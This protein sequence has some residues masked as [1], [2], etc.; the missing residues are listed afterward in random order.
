MYPHQLVWGGLDL[1][2]SYIVI[3]VTIISI[4][5]SR[6]KLK[7]EWNSVSRLFLVLYIWFS[8]TTVFAVYRDVALDLWI[9]FSKLALLFL[10][11]TWVTNDRSKLNA[12]I[13]CVIIGTSVFAIREGG[14]SILSAGKH[15]ISGP[16]GSS[17]NGNNEIARMW[18]L[19]LPLVLFMTYHA[20]SVWTRLGCYVLAFFFIVALFASQSR[21]AFLALA[22]AFGYLFL[23]SQRKMFFSISVA[24]VAGL[25][26]LVTSD[27]LQ[28]SMTS[29]YST[30][31]DYGEDRSFQGRVFAWNFAIDVVKNSPVMGDGFGAFRGAIDHTG[32]WKDAHS[33]YFEPLA[34][35]GFIGLLLF[36]SLGVA[37]FF[38]LNKIIKTCSSDYTK[39]W[40]RD[41]AIFL[42][43]SLIFYFVGGIVIS[44]TY[45]E[46]Y[47][48]MLMATAIMDN[49]LNRSN[50]Q[51]EATGH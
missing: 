8:I 11:T 35:H 42:K 37:A 4:F 44:H 33:I 12:L 29:R 2:W 17:F 46:T 32:T 49:Y 41:L 36:L 45:F 27:T 39:Y 24:V 16:P 20:N 38:K 19:V 26:L 48:F 18:G 13:W 7:I 22:V 34:E 47:Y 50:S 28:E 5:I 21:G 43:S 9:F 30:I 10:I 40:E 14:A 31:D 23:K 51:L 25:I 15:I 6:N 3:V 1:R